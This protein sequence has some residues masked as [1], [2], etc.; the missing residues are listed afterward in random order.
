[1]LHLLLGTDWTRNRDEL[2]RRIAA[3]VASGR[4]NRILMVPELISHDTER[5]LSAAAGDKC[6]RYAEVLSFTRLAR[7]VADFVGCAAESCL[8]NGGRVVAMAAAVR[9]MTSKL[10][11]YASVETR[12]EFLTELVDAVDEFKR[13]CISPADLMEA[14]RQTEG[15]LAQKLEELSLILE[16]Y[17][18][19]CQ[20]GKRDPRDRMTRL[21]EMMED[22]TFGKDHVFYIDGFPDFTRQNLAI[23]E[24]LIRVSPSVTVSLNCDGVS[25]HAMAF[26]KAGQTAAE[27]V[28][29]ARQAGI[30]VR[31]ELVPAGIDPLQ[32]MREKLFQG[33]ITEDTELSRHLRVV[34]AGS[35][36]QECAQT[37]EEIL[38]LVRGGCRYRDISVVCTDMSAYR[39]VIN[40]VFHR[41]GIPVYLSGTDDIL[42]KSVVSTVLTAMD[43][44]ADGFDQ[45]QM[46]RYLRSVLSPLDPDTCDLVENYAIT[47]GIR[48]ARWQQEW[49]LHPDGLGEEWTEEAKQRLADLNRARSLAIEP[50][51]RLRQGFRD[52]ENLAS[53][54][55]ALY[56]FLEDIQLAD[57]L[58]QLADRLDETGDNRS[59]Q[60]LNQLWEILVG[61]LEQLYDV[62]GK[63]VWDTESFS[64][65]FRLLLSQYDV[66][67]IP[68]VLDAVMAGPVTAMRCQQEKHLFVLGAVEG[69]LPS[70]GGSSGV[71]TDQERVALRKLGVPLTGGAME[72]LQA[73]F[74]EIYGVFC[75]AA[76]TVTISCPGGQPSFVYRR[77]LDMAGT[78]I[79][80]DPQLGA[81]LADAGE[82]GAYLARWGAA[83]A[84]SRLDLT[85]PYGVTRKKA[86]YT[87]G[88]VEET[89]IR[90]LYGTTLRLSASQVD[91]LA[92][93]RL[94]YFLKY[95]LRARERKEVTVD[96][97]EFGT[98]VHAVLEATAREVGTLGGFRQVS[99]EQTQQIA[100]KHSDDYAAQRFSQLDSQRTAYLLRRNT[101]ELEMVVRELWTELQTSEFDPVGYE[102]AFGDDCDMEPIH[103]PGQKMNGLL[104]GFVDRVD[105]W[106]SPE[107]NFFRVVDY[108]TGKKDFDYCD[109]FNGVGLQMLLY[110]FALED[111]GQKIVGVRPIPA[112]V[113]YFPAR[114]PMITTDGRLTDE[115][116][117]GERQKQWKRRGL[118]LSDEKVLQAMEP[119]EN[120]RRLDYTRHKD[121]SMKGNLAD[122]EQLRLLKRYIFRVLGKMVDEIASGRVDPNPYTRGTSHN[123]CTFCP[124]GSVCHQ[125]T[126]EGRRNYKAM[127]QQKFWEDV[128][129]EVKHDG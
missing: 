69:S 92:E 6:S 72:G 68:T 100:K 40:L 84:A 105:R 43:A 101:H 65:L 12:P 20:Q 10:K 81:A 37:A 129:R 88:T 54:V 80:A 39:S 115:D 60:E 38:A 16:A 55:R 91:Q 35:I 102:V 1:M 128:E 29:C 124:Y 75:G 99:L 9:Q 95:G 93:C 83:E 77:L 51:A 4:G 52:A 82:A 109:A 90:K 21:L 96:P 64:R 94:S 2:L 121:G 5:R 113:Q 18:A 108:K 31:I 48:G 122:R 106:E 125:Q 59:A 44:A 28:R 97:A 114:A 126:V 74:A 33:R 110:L 70:Y 61:A 36:Y 73:E 123:A 46:L 7:R 23:L 104:R 25:S 103:I 66:G 30:E 50:L 78:E 71:L 62:L 127:T 107:G 3:D 22:H 42:E 53:Q 87:L 112:G 11:A 118:L 85:A 117:E 13:C 111:G 8:D 119:G 86:A 27:L 19:L 49:T 26:E 47:W 120:P 41:C 67:T 45:R 17:D 15:S 79:S 116:A 76:E 56:G 32:P 57:R 24:H 98:Y 58:G 63:T 34:R 89:R 14:S